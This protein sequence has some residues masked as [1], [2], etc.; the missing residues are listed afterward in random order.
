MNVQLQR[1][2]GRGHSF[3]RDGRLLPTAPRSPGR[4]AVRRPAIPAP[5]GNGPYGE[6]PATPATSHVTHNRTIR[7]L[8]RDGIHADRP[9]LPD[10]Q[11]R[12]QGVHRA[13]SLFSMTGLTPYLRA[14]RQVRCG[15]PLATQRPR[16]PSEQEV[17]SDHG[18][19][20]VSAPGHPR[21][22]D[23]QRPAGV[24]ARVHVR[25]TLARA[26]VRPG[27]MRR[28]RPDG[29][30][31]ALTRHRPARPGA[32]VR[33]CI[34]R[35]ARG[36]DVDL[37]RLSQPPHPHRG[38]ATASPNGQVTADRSRNLCRA[39][40]LEGKPD[41]YL[42]RHPPPGPDENQFRYMA[43]LDVRVPGT[44]FTPPSGATSGRRLKS[45]PPAAFPAGRGDVNSSSVA[46]HPAFCVPA[47]APQ[48]Q[49]RA[50]R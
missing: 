5:A 49:P 38:E 21:G 4:L 50:R 48:V 10:R 19:N 43:E 41:S 2:T 17:T 27:R 42:G 33:C 28:S 8:A 36:R 20:N 46:A 47:A 22:G 37:I 9:G 1:R 44:P 31:S 32:T 6:P 15:T 3:P 18:R 45:F 13:R 16:K 29:L 12:T 7:P 35:N 23:A 30:A 40:T 26:M 25:Q 11:M 14:W 24:D 39:V 34:W